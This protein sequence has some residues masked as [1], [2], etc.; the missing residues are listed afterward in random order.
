MVDMAK[1]AQFAGESWTAGDAGTLASSLLGSQ[2]APD[3]ELERQEIE[4]LLQYLEGLIEEAKEFAS[5]SGAT[6]VR[7]SR[8]VEH[9]RFMTGADGSPDAI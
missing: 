6:V 3:L 4:R 7:L 1:S 8:D 5:R 2:L 9:G